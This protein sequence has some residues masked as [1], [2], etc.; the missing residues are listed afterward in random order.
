MILKDTLYVGALGF[1][2]AR[3][4]ERFSH[5]RTVPTR[6][7]MQV[8]MPPALQEFLQGDQK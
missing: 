4:R 8:E 3:I 7:V 1:K 2:L 5:S 6:L